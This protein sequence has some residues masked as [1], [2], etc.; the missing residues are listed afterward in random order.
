MSCPAS[1]DA[2][3]IRRLLFDGSERLAKALGVLPPHVTRLVA[4]LAHREARKRALTSEH[5]RSP[6]GSDLWLGVALGARAIRALGAEEVI[7][8]DDAFAVGPIPGRVGIRPSDPSRREPNPGHRSNWVVGSPGTA[9]RSAPDFAH[10]HDVAR[11]RAAACESSRRFS[12][13]ARLP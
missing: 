13:S 11:C 6:A 4:T 5:E 9:G 2:S 12:A 10:D 7:G 1:A 3:S 8:L